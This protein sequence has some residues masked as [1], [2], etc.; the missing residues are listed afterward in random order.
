V[1]CLAKC[2]IPVSADGGGAPV[3]CAWH[4]AIDIKSGIN[5]DKVPYR[6]IMT[7]NLNAWNVPCNIR[8]R[9]RFVTDE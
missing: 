5:A 9:Q 2:G 8:A 7:G 1:P 3:G 4:A 6:R